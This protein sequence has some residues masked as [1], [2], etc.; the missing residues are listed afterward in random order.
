MGAD[1]KPFARAESRSIHDPEARRNPVGDSRGSSL[2]PARA[3]LAL[4]R[5][6]GNRAVLGA[7]T[8]GRGLSRE[9]A[10]AS[11]P[12]EPAG[13]TPLGSSVARPW[14]HPELFQPKPPVLYPRDDP[15]WFDKVMFKAHAPNRVTIVVTAAGLSNAIATPAD[16][17]A[18][19]RPAA[20]PHHALKGQA[21]QDDTAASS[22]GSTL[23]PV[24]IQV[25]YEKVAEAHTQAAGRGAAPDAKPTTDVQDQL[26][27]ALTVVYHDEDKPGWEWSVQAQ[28]AFNSA[29]LSGVPVKDAY[30]PL[31]SVQV[32]SQLA[33]VKNLW[34]K[35]Q[36]QIFAQVMAGLAGDNTGIGQ[37]AVGGQIQVKVSPHVSLFLQAGVGATLGQGANRSEQHTGDA[38]VGGGVIYSF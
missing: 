37:A 3:V 1:S 28:V 23:D 13:R 18:G 19:A 15:D 8:R 9:G 25:Q 24:Q 35:V 16:A 17:P 26:Q 38:S 33:Y 4:Q 30:Q 22:A 29:I 11:A 27:V 36:G 32:G 21:A 2:D 34:D 6:S 7:L 31:S 20:R 12:S 14:E 5:G 10:P